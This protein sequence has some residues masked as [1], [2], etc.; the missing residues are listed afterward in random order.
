MPLRGMKR[1]LYIPDREDKRRCKDQDFLFALPR[2]KSIWS[3]GELY[4]REASNC[5]DRKFMHTHGSI[6]L[7]WL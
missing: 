6:D 3:T 5:M 2:M 7:Q 1:E 4:P